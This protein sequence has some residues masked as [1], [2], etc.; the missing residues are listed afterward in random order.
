[1]EEHDQVIV[2]KARRLGL[3]WLCLA[4]NLWLLLFRPGSAVLLFSRTDKEAVALLKRLKDMHLHLPK[5]LQASTGVD[6]DHNLAFP[7]LGSL[8]QA[9]PSTK[10]AGRSYEATSILVDEADYIPVL[11]KLL[12]SLKPC[13][14]GG[15]T[16][17]LVSSTDKKEPVSRFKTL[18]RG[19]AAGRNAYHLIF[20]P[21]TARPGR[22]QQWYDEEAASGDYE[23]DDMYH[24]FP[25]TLLEALAPMSASKRF[26]PEWLDACA[27]VEAGEE[28]EP[29]F[30]VWVEPVPGREYVVAADPS[31]G[32]PPLRTPRQLWCWTRRRGNNAPCSYGC[33]EPDI[34]AGRLLPI[35]KMYNDAVIC[36][37]RNNHGHAVIL[38]LR[39]LDAEDMI[40]RSPHDD[41]LGWLSSTK[42]KVQAMDNAAKAFRMVD[43]T[44]HDQA[45]L[46]ELMSIDA[47]TLKA[48]VGMTDDLAMA[49]T[50]GLA[51]L[52]WPTAA[53]RGTG[54]SV[55][56]E[57]EDVI[58]GSLTGGW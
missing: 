40:Y 16:I 6:N 24:E 49:I 36:P 52:R 32:Q 10:Q 33:Y 30:T 4:C 21:W 43:V 38:A 54:E 42:W 35:A 34:L 37:E 20:L 15:G 11:D 48:P 2:V 31:E 14:E 41:K 8:A 18:A 29:G 46:S 25:A 5:F 27:R 1:M 55:I 58:D 26:R 56:I 53:Y 57:P 45:T 23:Q 50:I 39:N 51:A 44:I 12:V 7:K 3:T 47:R 22:D 13:I 9:F 17:R 19:A 28:S